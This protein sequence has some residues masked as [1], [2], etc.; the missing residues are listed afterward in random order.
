MINIVLGWKVI[1]AQERSSSVVFS[2]AEIV[3]SALYLFTPNNFQ[4]SLSIGWANMAIVS[5]PP[6]PPP[7]PP[8]RHDTN[9]IWPDYYEQ[10]KLIFLSLSFVLS[11]LYLFLLS[12]LA[13]SLLSLRTLVS[14]YLSPSDLLSRLICF[15]LSAL[16][17]R[18]IYITLSA[19]LS[20]L[21]LYVSSF[22]SRP[23]N[24]TLS[25]LLSLIISLSLISCLALY[26]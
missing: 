13:V 12:C 18:L 5:S 16:L 20:R 25:D 1:Y 14:P 26:I 9:L 3:S 23:I 8:D 4:Y 10:G 6:P 7:P 17:S 21:S 11:F 2:S 19:L 15:T 22:L 24:I